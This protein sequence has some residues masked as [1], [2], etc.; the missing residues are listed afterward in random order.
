MYNLKR[1]IAHPAQ[2][3]AALKNTESVSRLY[4]GGLIPDVLKCELLVGSADRVLRA[5]YR[6]RWEIAW[7]MLRKAVRSERE[8]IHGILWRFWRYQ[9]QMKSQAED[10]RLLMTE[11][12]PHCR[13]RHEIREI[14]DGR[15][16]CPGCSE[17]MDFC[18][19]AAAQPEGEDD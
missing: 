11:V 13:E 12:C 9:I 4:L 1:K 2:L 17:T 14:S 7:V 8:R 3:P 6:N 5:C 19:L 18:E 10:L 15:Y 16:Q